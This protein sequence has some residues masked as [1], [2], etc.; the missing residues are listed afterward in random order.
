MASAEEIVR[1]KRYKLYAELGRSP[2]GNRIRRTKT[3]EANGIREARRLA[4][5]FE[6][7]LL[8]RLNYSSDM[9]LVTLADK[10]I[11]NY[12]STELAKSTLDNYTNALEC[13]ADY[14]KNIRVK[15]IT[16]L[17]I[18][19][20]FNN[21]RKNGRGSLEAKYKVL[22][23]LFKHAV[24]WYV[25]KDDDNPMHSVDK[26]SNVNKQKNKDFY[27]DDEIKLMLELIKELTEE[28]QL[29]IQLALVGGLRRGEIIAI[30]HDV[31]DF[32]NNTIFIKNAL[33]QSKNGVELKG[34]KTENV[35]TI[36][37]PESLMERIKR[38][39]MKKLNLKMEMGNLW[40]GHKTG[41]KEVIFL[42]SNEYG[43]SYRP[44]SVTQ[45][46][47]RFAIRHED[48]LRR[49][50]FHDLRHS[51]ATYLL[52]EGAN[53]KVVQ[54]RLGHK[55][56]KTTYNFYSHVTEKDDKKASDLFNDI[57]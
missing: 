37:L 20:F 43:K 24:K 9:F 12:A 21:E 33:S 8:E 1:G 39:Y 48:K 54:K 56:I 7:D 31:I 35:R 13:I 46:W 14:F 16:P 55:D 32:T 53:M 4:Q 47:N 41:G 51:S 2:N 29:M 30:T 26:P 18:T 10:W 27:R 42:F 36:T 44:D 23:S 34:T 3:V 11:K 49:I 15:E 57:L 28:Q 22:R 25:I 52:G 17:S 40:Q 45:F 6:D 19:E 50:R 38:L 5:E